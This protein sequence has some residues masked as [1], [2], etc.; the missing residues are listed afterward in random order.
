MANTSSAK[1]ALIN[2]RRK[3]D[4]KSTRNEVLKAVKA[5]NKKSAESL[6]PEAYKA[7]DKAAKMN[8]IHKNT[9]ARYKSRLAT[10]VGSIE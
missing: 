6:M 8:I 7:I 4:F 10:K 5:K 9:A 2:A 1:K 3:R